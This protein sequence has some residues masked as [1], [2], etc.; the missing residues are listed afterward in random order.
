MVLGS[1]QQPGAVG[2][3][4]DHPRTPMLG[5]VVPLSVE[6]IASAMDS[7]ERWPTSCSRTTS[8]NVDLILY[9]AR[10]LPQELESHLRLAK[11]STSCFRRTRVVT[12]ALNPEVRH[13][14]IL[15]SMYCVP[16]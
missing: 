12:A 4:V 10:E 7:L 15:P 14:T 2:L 13:A 1:L 6:E 11:D 5:L 16:C 3:D 8:N 9:F